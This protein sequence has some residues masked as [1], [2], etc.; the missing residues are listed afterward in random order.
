MSFKVEYKGK[1]VSAGGDKMVLIPSKILG[2]KNRIRIKGKI[3]ACEIDLIANPWRNGEHILKLPQSIMKKCAL[4]ED[5][6][7]DLAGTTE[8]CDFNQLRAVDDPFFA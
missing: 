7:I 4:N 3:N 1:I 6:D 2:T 8:A 5:D